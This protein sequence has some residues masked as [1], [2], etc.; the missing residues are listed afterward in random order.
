MKASRKW[1][2]E[3]FIFMGF[4]KSKWLNKYN[5][6]K[7]K[8]YLSYVDVILA[9]FD[10]EH[11][12]LHFLHFLNKRHYNIK[13]MIQKQIN[14]SIAFLDVDD[15]TWLDRSDITVSNSPYMA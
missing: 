14:H 2:E 4:Y 7:P 10:K 1:S 11:D 5:L 15:D 12:S 9:A 3:A 13:F 6:N 8:F